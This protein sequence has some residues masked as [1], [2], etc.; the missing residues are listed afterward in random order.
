MKVSSRRLSWILGVVLGAALP[1]CA[2]ET[3]DPHAISE[4][5]NDLK[6][7][8]PASDKGRG[9]PGARSADDAGVADDAAVR[10]GKGQGKA[11]GKNQG[12]GQGQD[13]AK[14]AKPAAADGGAQD[15]TDEDQDEGTDE[16][17]D[18]GV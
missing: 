9:R 11:K 16:D 15:G 18:E 13:K 2:A 12:K 17:Q 3:T 1:A 5:S 14:K 10:P 4:T 7:G 8:I 6:G